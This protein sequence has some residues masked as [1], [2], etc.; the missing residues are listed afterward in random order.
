[1]ALNNDEFIIEIGREMCLEEFGNRTTYGN[2]D[3][4]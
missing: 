1:M 4:L 2:S 3:S